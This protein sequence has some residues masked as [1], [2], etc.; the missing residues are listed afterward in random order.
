MPTQTQTTQLQGHV[1]EV[2]EAEGQGF[3]GFSVFERSAGM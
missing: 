1:F 3:E 2:G